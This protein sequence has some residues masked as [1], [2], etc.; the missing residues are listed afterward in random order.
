MAEPK[1]GTE[2]AMIDACLVVM[3][4]KGETEQQ[5]A[6]DTASQVEVAIATETT[7]AVKLIVKGKLIAQKKAVT[8]VTGNTL[9]LT[10]NVFNFEQAKI[11]QGGTLHYWTDNDHTSTQTTKTEFGIAGYEPP[12]AGSAEK[13]EVFDLDLYSAV[14][15]TS[16]DIVQYEKISYPNCTGQPFGVGAQD[17]TFNVNAI[18]I[19]S[20]PQKG[21]APYS[22]MT[23][24]EL[25]AITE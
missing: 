7:D 12:V 6:L 3:R 4:T 23:V 17:D 13:G 19:D 20:A 10:D 5:L 21:K 18:T 25:P 14:Y 16:G 22:I 2:V 9:T 15:D 24:K 8:T 11:I 1:R